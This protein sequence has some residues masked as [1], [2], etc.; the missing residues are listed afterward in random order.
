MNKKAIWISQGSNIPNLEV[1]YSLTLLVSI[2]WFLTPSPIILIIVL[3]NVTVTKPRFPQWQQEEAHTMIVFHIAQISH[4][5]IVW[6]SDID[7]LIILIG[8]LGDQH[9]DDSSRNN[10]MDCWIGNHKRY[11]DVNSIVNG[12]KNLQ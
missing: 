6:A 11:I 5:V 9:Q 7:V 10:F 8:Y 1:I 4:D 2:V 12:L 3:F